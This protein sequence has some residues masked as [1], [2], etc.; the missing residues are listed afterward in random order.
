MAG[1]D[2]GVLTRVVH[3]FEEQGFRVAGPGEVAPEL[4][5]AEGPVGRVE[6][7]PGAVSDVALGFDLLRRLGPYDVGQA[8]VVAG[9]RIEALEGNE[10]TDRMLARVA[11]RRGADGGRTAFPGVLVKRPKP[12]Q[13]LRIDMPAIG[14]ETVRRAGDAGLAGIAVMANSTLV[15]ERPVVVRD[16]DA[17]GLFVQG[18]SDTPS[19]KARRTQTPARQL[20]KLGK[21]RPGTR[22]HVDATKAAGLL[23]AIAPLLAS[24]GVVVDRGHVLAVESGEGVD[25]LIARAGTLRQWGAKRFRRGTGL[26]ILRDAGDVATAVRAGANA[27]LAG[28]A[29]VGDHSAQSDAALRAAIDEA[30][31]L[32]LFVALMPREGAS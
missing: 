15:A 28:V 17:A 31:H 32:G 23:G 12:G 21:R 22:H 29:L 27:G 1:G 11:A 25:A 30:D 3:F 9:G 24:R 18:F 26:A 2:D 5:V 4:L 6:A 16:A 20:V 13:E 7:Q 14:P 10:G 8:V 19:A